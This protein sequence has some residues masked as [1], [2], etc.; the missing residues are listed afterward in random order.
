MNIFD[1][2]G[3]LKYLFLLLAGVLKLKSRGKSDIENIGDVVD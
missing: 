1:I 2:L 3:V